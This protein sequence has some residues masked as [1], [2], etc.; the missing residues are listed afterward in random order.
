MDINE[1]RELQNQRREGVEKQ[2]SMIKEARKNNRDFTKNEEEEYQKLDGHFDAI[3]EIIQS[4][5]N[6]DNPP[7]VG[8]RTSPLYRNEK[9]TN[10]IGVK[11]MPNTDNYT[12]NPDGT[13]SRDAFN[14]YIQLGPNA[15]SPSEFRALA[16]DN[17]TAG[18]YLVTPRQVA[19]SFIQDLDDAVF[20]RKL[21]TQFQVPN[22]QSL[23]CP[24]LGNDLGDPTWTAELGTGNEDHDLD[25]QLRELNPHPAARRIKVSNKLLRSASLN[26]EDIVRNRMLQKM[27]VVHENGFLNGNGVNQPLGIFTVSDQGINTDRDV[28]T[29]N[30]P[31]N[32]TVDGLKNAV[33]H[34][35]PQYRKNAEW[36]MHRDV[37]LQITKLQDGNGRYLLESN[38]SKAEGPALLGFP[39]NI[40]EYAPNSL[41]ANSYVAALCAWKYYYIVDAMDIQ[42]QRLVELYAESH[43]TGY[44]V[45]AESDGMPVLSNAFVRVQLGS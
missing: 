21:A 22:A 3:S 25:L 5:K 34:L 36:V 42:I 12:Y 39:V 32:I 45:R 38:I 1:I 30:T 9:N 2:K 23:G 4:Y 19:N 26:P 20:I 8:M 37:F 43:Q 44:F 16:A 29:D 27:A 13:E 7:I 6:G 11:N 31:T 33:G 14:R 24:A 35:K 10:T 15:I 41:T 17:D 40:S 28:S 18:G